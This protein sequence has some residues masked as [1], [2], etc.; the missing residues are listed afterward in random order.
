[1]GNHHIG[2]FQRKPR[3]GALH[4]KSEILPW[5]QALST[6]NPNVKDQ[7]I[8]PSRKVWV[9]QY[10]Y[11]EGYT[12]K[13]GFMENCLVTGYYDAETGDVFGA[14]YKSLPIGQKP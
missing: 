5:G 6:Y 4:I 12:T 3:P 14:R 2:C 13:R 11:P 8:D 9:V 7:L 10:Y 1:M